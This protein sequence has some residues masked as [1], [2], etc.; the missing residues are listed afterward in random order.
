MAASKVVA[1]RLTITG[2]TFPYTPFIYQQLFL[3]FK[4]HLL[5][6]VAWMAYQGQ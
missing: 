3:T 1:E 5:L 2:D 6:L 4:L